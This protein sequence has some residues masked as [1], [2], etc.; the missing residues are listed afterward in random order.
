MSDEITRRT[1]IGTTAIVVLGPVVDAQRAP[2]TAGM[3]GMAGIDRKTLSAAVDCIIPA[4]DSMPS[5]SAAGAVGYLERLA[6]REAELA[7]QFGRALAAL[8]AGFSGFSETQQVDAMRTLERTDL[9]AFAALRDAVYEAYYTN[10]AIWP[11]LGYTFRKGPR[12][13]AALDPFDPGQLTRVQQL[14]KMYRDAD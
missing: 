2:D 13:T 10:P 6:A 12:K 3:A 1:F 9:P 5:A 7:Q 8:G 14:P 11:R 4:G